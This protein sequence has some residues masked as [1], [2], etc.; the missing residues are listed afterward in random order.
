MAS[1]NTVNNAHTSARRRW[2]LVLVVIVGILT[3]L[4]GVQQQH[5]INQKTVAKAFDVEVDRFVQ[6]RKSYFKQHI[7]ALNSVSA[8][9]LSRSSD[10]A[11]V[12]SA[13]EVLKYLE[14][15]DVDSEFEGLY[16]LGLIQRVSKDIEKKYLQDMQAFYGTTF[17]IRS[18]GQHLN[19]R[20][21]KWVVSASF[22]A[23]NQA[24]VGVD[25]SSEK[26]R[27]EPIQAMLQGY[28]V[29]NTGI[30]PTKAID[31]VQIDGDTISGFLLYKAIEPT[32]NLLKNIA[33]AVVNFDHFAKEILQ[34]YEQSG[35]RFPM[36]VFIFEDASGKCLVSYTEKQGLSHDCHEYEVTAQNQYERSDLHQMRNFYSIMRPSSSFIESLHL[37]SPFSVMLFGLMITTL[38]TAATFVLYRQREILAKLVDQ[39]THDLNQSKQEAILAE[40]AKDE[41]L[42]KLSHQLRTPLNGIFGVIQMFRLRKIDPEWTQAVN[43]A[44]KCA[45]HVLA[46]IEDVSQLDMIRQR[47]F[48]LTLDV[49]DI[50]ASTQLA[51]DL[52]EE[53]AR[54]HR[55]VFTV[56]IDEK[57]PTYLIGDERRYQQILINLIENS[58]RW[59]QQ[60]QITLQINVL[61]SCEDSVCLEF[62]LVDT[63]QGMDK[64]KLK[65]VNA[66]TEQLH[67]NPQ[68]V[69]LLPGFGLRIV[70]ELLYLM[71]AKMSVSSTV[72][73]GTEVTFRITFSLPKDVTLTP[74]TVPQRLAIEKRVLFLTDAPDGVSTLADL[75]G[76]CVVCDSIDRLRD[77]LIGFEEVVAVVVDLDS[78]ANELALLTTGELQ[79]LMASSKLLAFVHDTNKA[80]R[81][82]AYALGMTDIMLKP[83]SSLDILERL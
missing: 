14:I 12:D 79:T 39:R 24:A 5:E 31:L 74:Q 16:G 83:L 48:R 46:L 18:L 69:S 57:V 73:I 11:L 62:N 21:D 42:T 23:R 70:N 4:I 6:A 72:G 81:I 47:R 63:G 25:V 38:V 26:N 64:D 49:F 44:D 66:L 1:M 34:S 19:Y 65:L 45:R 17:S 32:D 36:D 33:Y 29:Q 71:N 28:S 53:K 30:L 80:A 82:K 13:Q 3:T 67:F 55:N 9:L 52:F 35:Q 37:L 59:T 2:P 43:I 77:A 40:Q 54:I 68:H 50:R 58:I 41:F 51:K 20:G 15:L 22:P 61:N 78:H 10:I 60:G 7:N 27:W 75:G 8:L 56:N 76:Q